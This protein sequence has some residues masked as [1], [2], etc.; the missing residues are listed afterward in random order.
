[1]NS[2]LKDINI[3][4]KMV[5][6]DIDMIAEMILM[7]ED[8]QEI[9][10][11]MKEEEEREEKDF[12]KGRKV[13]KA[14]VYIV[15]LKVKDHNKIEDQVAKIQINIKKEDQDLINARNLKVKNHKSLKKYFLDRHHIDHYWN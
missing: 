5:E 12:R 3:K 6:E 10:I 14:K 15:V 2:D 7:K 9:N 4:E 1:M 11:I 8:N 13:Q